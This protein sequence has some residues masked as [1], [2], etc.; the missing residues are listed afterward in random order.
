[1]RKATSMRDITPD[2]LLEIPTELSSSYVDLLG[3]K[4]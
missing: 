3:A 4:R 2:R 1:M